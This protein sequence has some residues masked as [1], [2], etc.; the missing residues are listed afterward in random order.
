MQ[1]LEGIFYTNLTEDLTQFITKI[2]QKE[3]IDEYTIFVVFI[4]TN[5]INYNKYWKSH[6]CIVLDIKDCAS[7]WLNS[8]NGKYLLSLHTPFDNFKKICNDYDLLEKHIKFTYDRGICKLNTCHCF[9]F[10]LHYSI[11]PIEFNEKRFAVEEFIT[12]ISIN[13][14]EF[15]KYDY[16]QIKPANL[17]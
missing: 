9:Y 14:P 12:E 2:R 16:C 5:Q 3:I 6:D 15:Y 7:Y 10:A 11:T 4:N 1:I 8:S 13:Y 17:M